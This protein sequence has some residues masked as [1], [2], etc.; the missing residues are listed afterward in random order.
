MLPPIQKNSSASREIEDFCHSFGDVIRS[1]VGDLNGD[2]DRVPGGLGPRAGLH[3]IMTGDDGIVVGEAG[4]SVLPVASHPPARSALRV[5]QTLQL[6]SSYP[7]SS[8]R[9]LFEKATEVMPQMMLSW[10]Y[11]ISSWSAR[12]S[13]S[14]QVASSEPVAKALPFGKN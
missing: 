2:E 13:K 14:L 5:S 8:R 7:A 1:G 11:T 3:G 4:I 6:K 9:P 12:R 10:E